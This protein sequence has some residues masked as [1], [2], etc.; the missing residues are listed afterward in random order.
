[1]KNKII[2]A[3]LKLIS[4]KIEV[5]MY[6]L[7]MY[8]GYKIVFYL[9][10]VVAINLYLKCIG[11]VFILNEN[12]ILYLYSTTAQVIAG[13][14]G[15]TLTGYVFFESKLN[16]IADKDETYID[17][18]TTLKIDYFKDIFFSG[19]ISGISIILSLICLIIYNESKYDQYDIGAIFNFSSTIAV[20]SIYTIISFSWKLLNPNKIKSI[21]GKLKKQ[22]EKESKSTE[23]KIQFHKDSFNEQLDDNKE[24]YYDFMNKYTQMENLVHEIADKLTSI[25]SD[26]ERVNSK[27][28]KS[29]RPIAATSIKILEKNSIISKEES[30]N[31]NNLRKY[32]NVLIHGDDFKV[33]SE[34]FKLLNDTYSYIRAKY[35]NVKIDI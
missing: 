4:K 29:R 32:R 13:L 16:E 18:I 14:Y 35:D 19:L 27:I 31:L 15:L 3:Y 5:G 26:Y 10:F 6:I 21:S 11:P 25:Y 23:R 20:L 8:T 33:D 12:Q 22:I 30:E 34:V 1:M 28:I 17:H 7:D 24:S 2:K 9:S